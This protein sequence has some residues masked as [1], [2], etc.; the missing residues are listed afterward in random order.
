MQRLFLAVGGMEAQTTDIR[1]L[2]RS[3]ASG[4]AWTRWE[5]GQKLHWHPFK[6]VL[7][8]TARAGFHVTTEWRDDDGEMRYGSNFKI[9]T[10]G[11]FVLNPSNVMSS[12]EEIGFSVR[13][14]N[15][16]RLIDRVLDE[17]FGIAGGYRAALALP[18]PRGAMVDPGR[19]F[20]GA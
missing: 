12:A 6:L 3:V 15:E 13:D 4:P 19:F 8:N 5:V 7:N 20:H 2:E 10:T 18:L 1:Y 17:R 9:R 14:R 16:E 11:V